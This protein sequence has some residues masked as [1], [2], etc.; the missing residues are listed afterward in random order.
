VR[1]VQNKAYLP[2]EQQRQEKKAEIKTETFTDPRD[3]KVYKTVKIGGQVWMAENLNFNCKGSKCNDK[4]TKNAEKYGRLYDWKTAKKACPSGWHL[5][6]DEEWQTLIDF[7]GGNDI[8]GKR[9]KAKNGWNYR[10]KPGTNEFGFSALPGGSGSS[11]GSFLFAGDRYFWWSASEDGSYYA[12]SWFTFY[13][14]EN[15]CWGSFD[16]SRL[17]SVRCVEDKPPTKEQK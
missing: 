17:F 3:G 11:D 14:A 13:G 8:A 16:K 10:E 6:S 4:D 7:A 12:Y 9:L 5:P 2:Q 1:C 15:V